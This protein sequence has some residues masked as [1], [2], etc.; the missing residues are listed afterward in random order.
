MPA[1]E[2]VIGQDIVELLRS[3]LSAEESYSPTKMEADG[4]TNLIMSPNMNR[5]DLSLMVTVSLY[6]SMASHFRAVI[7]RKLK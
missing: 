5:M 1:L 2:L 3:R 6:L 4:V 7:G